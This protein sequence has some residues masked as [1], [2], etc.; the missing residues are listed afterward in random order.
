MANVTFGTPIFSD[1]N[2]TYTPSFSGGSWSSALPLTNLQD[3]RLSKV[4]RSSNALAAS[5]TFDVDLGVARSCRVFAVPKH[6]FSLAS[7]M[8][9]RGSSSATNFNVGSNYFLRSEQLDNASWTK[10]NST[11]TANAANDSTGAATLD[12]IAE[13]NTG[14]DAYYVQQSTPTLTNS[15]TQG[16]AVEFKAAERTWAW[17]GTLNKAGVNSVS[18]INLSTGALGT[19]SGNH[20]ASVTDMGSGVYK[21]TIFWNASTG[22]SAPF[23]N[24][25]TATGDLLQTHTG[26]VGNGIYAG[27]VHGIEA[28]TMGTYETTTT[29]VVTGGFVVYDSG[30]VDVYHDDAAL[31][32]EDLAEMRAQGFNPGFTHVASSAQSAR[33]WRFDITDTANAS[34]YVELGRLIIAGGWQPTINMAYGAKLGWDTSTSR[35]ETDGGAAVYNERVRRRTAQIVIEGLPEAEAHTNAFDWGRK[36]GIAKQLMFVFDP[37]DT[38][39]MH[40]RSFLGVLKELT[41][42]DFPYYA[43]NTVPISVIEEI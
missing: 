19:V 22:G 26:V 2:Q 33:Y 38:T 12:K 31:T 11:I 5:T 42:L 15:A 13:G 40:R 21:L 14:S 10:V 43:R 8:R 36:L 20:T 39:H 30:T 41:A 25:G 6:N 7:S 4:A 23:V 28:A 16:V 37:S 34:G 35:T 32:A 18:Y 3:R 9:I 24:F 17:I 29:A 27:R 1:T